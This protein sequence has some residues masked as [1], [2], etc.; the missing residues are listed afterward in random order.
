MS[1]PV[2]R[3]TC[4]P[5]IADGISARRHLPGKGR[6][7]KPYIATIWAEQSAAADCLL[8][9]LLRRSRFRHP[10]SRSVIRHKPQPMLHRTTH[11]VF[12]TN[13]TKK[14]RNLRR[15]VVRSWNLYGLSHEG[16]H[17]TESITH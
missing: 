11:E 12:M 10:L 15:L 5:K 16:N 2:V 6:R 14:V 1:C 9:P 17:I 13:I 7:G 3:R 4:W 8:C